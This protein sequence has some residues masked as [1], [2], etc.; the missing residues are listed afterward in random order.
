M[1]GFFYK[2]SEN[3]SR[4]LFVWSFIQIIDC[5]IIQ[6]IT[7][8]TPSRSKAEFIL[9]QMELTMRHIFYMSGSLLHYHFTLTRRRY[10]F[11]C[12]SLKVSL[13][14]RYPASCSVKSGLSSTMQRPRFPLTSI[15][16][17]NNYFCNNKNGRII[18]APT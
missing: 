10:I 1:L 18:S 6:A 14:G 9:L 12:A 11:C 5:S 2:I 16:I 13:T 7:S 4:I 17:H 3:I 15:I 8:A